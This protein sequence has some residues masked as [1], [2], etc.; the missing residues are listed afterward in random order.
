MAQKEEKQVILHFYRQQKYSENKKQY[1]VR[2]KNIL[3]G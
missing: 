1:I 2:R 3:S